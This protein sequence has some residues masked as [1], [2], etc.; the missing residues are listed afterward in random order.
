MRGFV[1]FLAAAAIAA[2]AMAFDLQVGQQLTV[3]G[4]PL[5]VDQI[6]FKAEAGEATKLQVALDI[7]PPGTELDD[8]AHAAVSQALCRRVAGAPLVVLG[9][10][11]EEIE[12]LLWVVT[13]DGYS[14]S[15]NGLWPTTC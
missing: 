10:P 7:L 5:A 2:P 6:E 12:I 15:R 14:T 8:A 3:E 9:I 13:I 1:T 4:H 11:V